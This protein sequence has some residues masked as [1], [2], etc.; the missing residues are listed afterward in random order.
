[1]PTQAVLVYMLQFLSLQKMFLLQTKYDYSPVSLLSSLLI[2]KF[3][4]FMFCVVCSSFANGKRSNLCSREFGNITNWKH[5]RGKLS[6][7]IIHKCNFHVLCFSQLLNFIV[8]QPLS[9]MSMRSQA[10]WHALCILVCSPPV[11]FDS[12]TILYKNNTV[13][14]S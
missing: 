9:Y 14:G 1:M 10:S 12:L 13:N 5:W 2:T 8:W 3:D 6:L 4:V 7:A 11:N